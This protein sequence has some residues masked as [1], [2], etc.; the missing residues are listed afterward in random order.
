MNFL[1]ICCHINIKVIFLI[2]SLVSFS[3]HAIKQ[4][5]DYLGKQLY[6][7]LWVNWHPIKL[8]LILVMLIIIQIPL[9]IIIIE[10]K[11]KCV[12]TK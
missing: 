4:Y 12:S 8:W 11:H 3:F 7:Y 1:E 5:R 2:W 10:I 6:L 9:K